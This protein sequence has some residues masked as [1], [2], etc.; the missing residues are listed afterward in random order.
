VPA[1]NSDCWFSNALG[2]FAMKPILLMAL[3]LCCGSLFAN[4]PA[5]RGEDGTT[6]AEKKLHCERKKSLGS[7]KV[8]R[9]CMTESERI[10]AQDAAQADLQRLG[11]CSGNDVVCR[12]DLPRTN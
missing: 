12:G 2:E 4:E 5:A 3:I 8:E 6:D 1:A 7:N 9:V 10:A 11:R